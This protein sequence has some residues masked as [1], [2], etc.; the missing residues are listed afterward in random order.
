MLRIPRLLPNMPLNRELCNS[1]ER[2]QQTDEQHR[3]FSAAS[4]VVGVQL[5]VTLP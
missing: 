3:G 4:S 2:H 1:N 5:Q